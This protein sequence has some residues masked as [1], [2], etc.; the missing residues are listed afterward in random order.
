MSMTTQS[1]TAAVRLVGEFTVILV[2]VFAALGAD[3]WNQERIRVQ[4][5]VLHIE[6]L[7]SDIRADA[8]AATEVL[9]FLPEAKAARDSLLAAV[10]GHGPLPSDLKAVIIRAWV[11]VVLPPTLTWS[12]LSRSGGSL[13]ISD[14]GHRRDIAEYYA[15]REEA[16]RFMGRGELRGRYPFVEA[17][18][19]IGILENPP[20]TDAPEA[21][22]SFPDMRTRLIG[23]GGH[24]AV[25]EAYLPVL[26]E[27]SDVV[28]ERLGEEG[29]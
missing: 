4:S 10:E 18:Y 9:T 14:R 19:Q 16:E 11:T 3:R 12:D 22:L 26:R 23:L 29:G 21:F 1:R 24:Y 7:V 28:L 2:G 8:A 17:Q 25:M 13:L 6:A 20:R 5:E 15:V 27:A